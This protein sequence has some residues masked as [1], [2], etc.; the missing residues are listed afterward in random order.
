MSNYVRK[1]KDVYYLGIDYGYGHGIELECG[2]DTRKEA[3]QGRK[4]YLD[5][6]GNQIR[7][8]KIVKKR[9]KITQ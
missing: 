9:E 6:I 8:I 7:L 5:N 2:Y 1:T 3:Q 4:E